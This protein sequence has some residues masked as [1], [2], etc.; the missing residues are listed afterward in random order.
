[1]FR[2]PMKWETVKSCYPKARLRLGF[3]TSCVLLILLSSSSSIANE[4]LRKE[5]LEK[6]NHIE[7]F[8]ADFHQTATANDGTE[9]EMQEGR[10]AFLRP[11]KF[12]WIVHKPFE[13]QVSINGSRMQVYD[14]DLQQ[15]THSKVDPSELSFAN[16]LIDSESKAFDDFE[17]VRKGNKYLLSQSGDDS[18]IA[19]LSLLFNKEKIER[20]ELQ[21]YFGTKIQFR[22][23]NVRLNEE[24]END[25]FQIKV[26]PDTEVI[27]RGES[28]DNS[29]S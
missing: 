19:Q 20:I 13:E 25:L 2:R 9:E 28:G 14:P 15:L 17:I 18:Q 7:S 21:D 5:L 4:E 16:L 24:I 12:L 26:P 22:F 8:Q 23:F 1:M 11:E 6:L 29:E 10:I 3:A 27:G